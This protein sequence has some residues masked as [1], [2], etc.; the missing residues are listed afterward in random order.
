MPQSEAPSAGPDFLATGSGAVPRADEAEWQSL[1]K[2]LRARQASRAAAAEETAEPAEPAGA[3]TPNAVDVLAAA[4]DAVW[5]DDEGRM[6]DFLSPEAPE[7]DKEDAARLYELMLVNGA[8][9]AEGQA[10]VAELFSV[11]RVTKL[12]RPSMSLGKGF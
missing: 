6:V 9:A 8:T 12:L 1:A 5:G 3:A 2:R 10:K 7:Q 11:P 4:W